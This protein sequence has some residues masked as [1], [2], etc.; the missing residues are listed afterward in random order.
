[1]FK[2]STVEAMSHF[3]GKLN[4]PPKFRTTQGSSPTSCGMPPSS[5]LPFVALSSVVAVGVLPVAVGLLASLTD[6]DRGS[7]GQFDPISS[8]PLNSVQ[9]LVD[10]G[11]HPADESLR[12]K[13]KCAASS[14]NNESEA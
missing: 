12:C 13:R 3:S 14:E 7:D 4:R 10:K 8:G 1:M 9:T 6:Q 11:K 5:T 2:I